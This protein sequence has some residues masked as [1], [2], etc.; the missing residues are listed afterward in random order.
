MKVGAGA[1]A[2]AATGFVAVVGAWFLVRARVMSVWVAMGLTFTMLAVL[3]LGSGRVRWATRVDLAAA[4]AVGLGSGAALYVATAAFFRI[5]KRWDSLRRQTLSLYQH[6][7]GISLAR[8][9]GVGALLV[10]PGEE[11]FWRGLVQDLAVAAAG[12]LRGAVVAWGVYVAANVASGS[13]PV[14]LG[15][16]VGGVAWAALAWWSGGVVASIAC[17]VV[18]TALMIAR[19]PI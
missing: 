12:T 6:R 15:A 1:A 3:S 17:H 11:L 16:A 9:L 13:L 4:L 5:T 14:V 7:Q 19:P 18:W 8:T 10:S 2:L